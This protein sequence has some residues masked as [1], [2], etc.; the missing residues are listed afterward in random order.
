MTAA[1]LDALV[2]RWQDGD[3]AAAE[4]ALARVRDGVLRYLLGRRLPLHEAEDVAQEVCLAV[5][6]AVPTWQDT[7]RPFWSLVF[8]VASRK[9]VDRT[10][11]AVRRPVC[12]PDDGSAD[13]LACPQPGPDELVLV[14]EQASGV[15][16]LLD[17]L[18]ARQRD[19]VLLRVL[20]GL[21]VG[22]TAA[23]LGLAHGSVHV[24]QH[25]A[26]KKLRRHLE[27]AQ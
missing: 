22:D 15:A 7:G 3:R 11:A 1:D 9:L 27:D 25:R 13:R 24:L 12:V 18:P 26:M 23:A 20:V 14:D 10:R 5:L 4:Q 6:T 17:L 2:R 19:V 21:S 16:R 8:T